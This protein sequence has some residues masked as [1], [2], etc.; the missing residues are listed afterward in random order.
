MKNTS[1]YL[2]IILFSFL[3]SH[4]SSAG[5]NGIVGTL[6]DNFRFSSELSFT[7]NYVARGISQTNQDPAIQGM[8]SIVHK[9]SGLYGALW[10]SSTSLHDR[11]L[12]AHF[13]F[14]GA[15]PINQYILF[16]SYFVYNEFYG[17]SKP[18]LTDKASDIT[19]SFLF[20]LNKF[21]KL[22][23]KYNDTFNPD[24]WQESG[25][26][27]YTTPFKIK[28]EA[29]SYRNLGNSYNLF[30]DIL[31][32]KKHKLN[33]LLSKFYSKHSGLSDEDNYS[34]TFTRFI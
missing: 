11:V 32:L 25:H 27:L 8:Y 18:Y 26:I 17:K 24:A 12:E 19:V 23:T 22:E 29:G 1:I 7:S 3:T 6:D 10:A 34:L 30:Y 5:F 16:N 13:V 9:K 2:F 21:G 31:N 14:G 20:D 15:Y 4:L 33:I 28:I